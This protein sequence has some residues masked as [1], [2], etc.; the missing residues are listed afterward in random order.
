MYV[1]CGTI[2]HTI[3]EADES[4]TCGFNSTGSTEY[5]VVSSRISSLTDFA[6]IPVDQQ[7]YCG[8]RQAPQANFI[9]HLQGG[10]V[11]SADVLVELGLYSGPYHKLP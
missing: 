8:H 1:L 10:R 9:A 3:P 5:Y 11:H 6:A 2:F 4:T 7:D